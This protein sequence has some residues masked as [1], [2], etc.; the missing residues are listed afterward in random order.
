VADKALVYLMRRPASMAK[1]RTS[2]VYADREFIG[3]VDNDSYAIAYVEPGHRLIWTNWTGISNE[4]DFVAG[5]TYV[6]EVFP[7]LLQHDKQTGLA[8]LDSLHEYKTS[9]A[10][11]RATAAGQVANR[12]ERAVRRGAKGAVGTQSE[13]AAI[14]LE[15]SPPPGSVLVPAGTTV[16]LELTENVT[17]AFSSAGETIWFRVVEDVVLDGHLMI[18]KGTPVSGLVRRVLPARP[19]GTGGSLDIAVATLTAADG[20]PVPVS[21]R[22]M[23]GGRDRT[24]AMVAT[25]AAVGLF[26]MLVKGRQAFALAGDVYEAQSTVPA[27]FLPADDSEPAPLAEAPEP[28]QPLV[29]QALDLRMAFDPEKDALDDLVRIGVQSDLALDGVV[30]DRSGDVVLPDPVEASSVRKSKALYEYTFPAWSVVRHLRFNAA[31]GTSLRLTGK[32]QGGEPVVVTVKVWA[33]LKK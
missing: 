25:T 13:E 17:S 23:A 32:R 27:W 8:L 15:T 26:G 33:R 29:L 7:T 1:L 19:G 28:S 11:E 12:Y 31:E 14:T 24:N 22:V 18:R 6:L 16:M 20:T 9:T 4:F 5:Q 3:T 30:I 2:F 21:A 10:E